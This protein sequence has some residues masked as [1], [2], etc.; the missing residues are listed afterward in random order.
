M[1]AKRRM[2]GPEFDAIRPLL[3]I[4]EDRINAARAALVDGQTLQGVAN[5]YGWGA[6][7]TVGDAVR[8]VWETFEKY[9]ETQRA[10]ASAG[11]LLPPGWEQVTLI[12]P[13]H[14]IAAF[15][16]QIAAEAA[17]EQAPAKRA[18]R[19]SK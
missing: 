18:A 6:R 13:S 14:L 11:T 3:N 9:N 12:A 2:T 8:V 17:G 10:A 15:R 4:S 5:V 19:K 16:Q 1:R 7:Q